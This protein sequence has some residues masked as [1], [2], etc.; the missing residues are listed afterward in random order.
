MSI[1]YIGL[2]DMSCDANDFNNKETRTVTQFF[3]AD[4]GAEGN[5]RHFDKI[6]GEYVPSYATVKKWVDPFKCG[7]FSTCDEP[8]PGRPKRE[9]APRITDQIHELILEDCRISAK[10]IA[11]QQDISRECIASI[12]DEDLDMRKFPSTWSEMPDRA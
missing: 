4:Q 6:L 8:R 5:S 2:K 3:P 10:S 7:D 1:C 12:T 11:A 9:T